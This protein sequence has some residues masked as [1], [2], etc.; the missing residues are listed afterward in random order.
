MAGLVL[1]LAAFAVLCLESLAKLGLLVIK[2]KGEVV[3]AQSVENFFSLCF[4]FGGVEPSKEVPKLQL[5]SFGLTLVILC[6]FL[7]Q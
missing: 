1:L 3:L 5:E 4:I 6:E 2:F 7:K